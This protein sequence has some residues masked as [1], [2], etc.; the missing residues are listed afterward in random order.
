MEK[1]W[2]QLLK[3]VSIISGLLGVHEQSKQSVNQIAVPLYAMSFFLADHKVCPL[4]LAF[5]I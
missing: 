5:D 1:L 3:D 4:F 2:F